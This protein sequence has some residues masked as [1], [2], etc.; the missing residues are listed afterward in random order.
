MNHLTPD[1]LI[2]ALDE[3]LSADARCHLEACPACRAQFE[4]LTVALTSTRD[5]DVPEPS[6]LFWQHFSARV[7]SAVEAEGPPNRGWPS[8]FRLPVLAPL[9][10]LAL[11]IAV[12]V[13]TLPQAIRPLPID[14]AELPGGDVP[15]N[16]DGW[17]LVADV[18]GDLD[19]DTA[20]AA[21]LSVE[22]GAVDR[23]VMDLT[24]DEQRELTAL[25]QA[26][27]RGKS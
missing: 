19:W 16:D 6:P 15:L 23:A 21:G 26:E 24:A 20:M 9:V 7:R 22:P 1:Q 4:E 13:V 8:W 27:L 3:P 5:L 11:V 12:L 14:V 18:V 17:T 25:L 10:G 2:D